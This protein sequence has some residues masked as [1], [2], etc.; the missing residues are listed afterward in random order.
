M[1]IIKKRKDGI[2]QTYHV[3]TPNNKPTKG[4]IKINLSE[5]PVV[6]TKVYNSTYSKNK[7]AQ[8]GQ[9]YPELKIFSSFMSIITAYYVEEIIPKIQPKKLKDTRIIIE[10][11]PELVNVLKKE[12][13]FYIKNGK[14][15]DN[16]LFLGFPEDKDLD[17]ITI[18]YSKELWKHINPH[19]KDLLT[20]TYKFGGIIK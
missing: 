17:K 8:I 4:I 20:N 9:K 11:K 6:K 15:I 14:L 13:L 10:M 16:T 19:L 7:A 2:T 3:K 12:K 1:K 18:H 5:H